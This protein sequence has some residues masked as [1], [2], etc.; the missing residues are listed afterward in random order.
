MTKNYPGKK[1]FEVKRHVINAHELIGIAFNNNLTAV[2]NFFFRHNSVVIVKC[3]M[4]S[5]K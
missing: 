5:E 3:V 1:S 2:I 4:G